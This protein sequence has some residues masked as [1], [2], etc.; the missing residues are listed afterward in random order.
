MFTHYTP[1]NPIQ[2]VLYLQDENGVDW[3]DALKKFKADTIKIVVNK[4]GEITS[5]SQDAGMLF[6]FNADVYEVK[7]LPESKNRLYYR[8]GKVV[9]A[10][11]T[12]EFKAKAVKDGIIADMEFAK[13]VIDTLRLEREYTDLTPEKDAQLKE[14]AKKYITLKSQLEDIVGKESGA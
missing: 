6:P 2:N 14:A 1:E 13:D 7:S 12:P 11:D 4:A 9:K 10:E 5:A 8:N 3:Y